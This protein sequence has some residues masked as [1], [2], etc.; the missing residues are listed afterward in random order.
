MLKVFSKN[1]PILALMS[2]LHLMTSCGL[3]VKLPHFDK[4][5]K[6]SSNQTAQDGNSTSGMTTTS[7]GVELNLSVS[8]AIPERRVWRLTTEQY[9]AKVDE[10]L[11]RATKI[12]SMFDAETPPS[13]GF[14]NEADLL[15]AGGSYAAKLEYAVYNA[16]ND[17]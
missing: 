8:G 3:P 11:G 7:D 2:S 17:S 12:D 10:L 4:T 6:T 9:A 1:F 5:G 14:G 15:L 13:D 16:V